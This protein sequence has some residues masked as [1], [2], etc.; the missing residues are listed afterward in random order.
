MYVV[1]EGMRWC[2]GF[3]PWTNNIY[4]T[5]SSHVNSSG[6]VEE[7]STNNEFDHIPRLHISTYSSK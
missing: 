1:N 4:R 3:R 7:Y 2:K 6:F 5:G